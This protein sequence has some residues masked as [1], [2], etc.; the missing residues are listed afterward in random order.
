MPCSSFPPWTKIEDTQRIC[1]RN[2]PNEAMLV[3]T[4]RHKPA[5]TPSIQSSPSFFETECIPAW[6]ESTLLWKYPCSQPVRLV[7]FFHPTYP[8]HQSRSSQSTPTTTNPPRKLEILLHDSNTLGMYS[9]QIC[10]FKEMDQESFRG[11]LEGHDGLRLPADARDLLSRWEERQ[12]DFSD[13][14]RER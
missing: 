14:S 4:T 12:R 1:V 10:V 8:N 13:E 9:T 6:V 7:P 11:F 5:K 3:S 2:H